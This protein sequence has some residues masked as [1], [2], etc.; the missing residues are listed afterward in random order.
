M[1]QQRD[2]AVSLSRKRAIEKSFTCSPLTRCVPEPSLDQ[3]GLLLHLNRPA[4]I[5]ASIMN[6][7]VFLS[8]GIVPF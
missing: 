5:E 4:R 6:R 2:C 7:P 8:L 3:S 1:V